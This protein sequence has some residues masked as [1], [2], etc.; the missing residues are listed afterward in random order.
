VVENRTLAGRGGETFLRVPKEKQ[1]EAVRFLLNNALTTPKKLLNPAIISQFRYSGVANDIS[2]QQKAVLQSL[3]NASRLNRLFDAELLA[4]DQ[5]YSVVEL[6]ADVQNGL[7]SEL[8]EE[9]P[10]I[11]PLRRTLQRAY[12]DLLKGELSSK[13]PTARVIVLPSPF[14]GED[15]GERVSELRAV[16][17][18]ALRGLTGI[19]GSALPKVQDPATKVHLEDAQ[20]EIEAALDTKKK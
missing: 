7:W 9:H 15:S 12:V 6:V 13:E 5:A 3:L 18:A 10:K 20:S 11:D 17:R 1:K 16:A 4:P 14:G 19:I 2:G 8:K